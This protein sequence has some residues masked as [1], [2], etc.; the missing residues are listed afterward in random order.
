MIFEIFLSYIILKISLKINQT[1]FKSLI[2]KLKELILKKFIV[3]YIK[4]YLKHSMTNTFRK[5]PSS[6]NGFN[7]FFKFHFDTN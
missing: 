1:L 2:Q 6:N 3:F 5:F 7:F 4:C